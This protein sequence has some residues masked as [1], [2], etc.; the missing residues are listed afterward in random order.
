MPWRFPQRDIE[1]DDPGEDDGT[2]EP[3]LG[4]IDGFPDI[5]S[6]TYGD[7]VHRQG[8]L[9]QARWAAGTRD[10]CEEEHDGR[11]PD[12]DDEPSLGSF[13]G[14]IDQRQS[15]QEHI[16]PGRPHQPGMDLELGPAE[17][18]AT[19]DPEDPVH[20]GGLPYDGAAADA[21]SEAGRTLDKIVRGRKT[22]APQ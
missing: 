11:E 2:G 13:D 1:D 10:D 16:S 9:D 17:D 21:A 3:S 8:G 14:V 20:F 15:W 19:D 5:G 7:G 22:K 6:R 18:E 4:S 12:V